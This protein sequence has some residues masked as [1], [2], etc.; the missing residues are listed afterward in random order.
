M[1][2]GGV[3][4]RERGG[5]KRSKLQ[6]NHID[7]IVEWLELNCQLTLREISARIERQFNITV[8]QQTV[9]KYLDGRLISLKK[10]HIETNGMNSDAN[11][12]LRRAYV[13]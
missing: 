12:V 7:Q 5:D 13:E 8:S 11:K 6:D 1:R 9:S 2:K 4:R 10:I 3:Q